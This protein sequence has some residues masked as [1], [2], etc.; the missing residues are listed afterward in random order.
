MT[1][2]IKEGR[3]FAKMWFLEGGDKDWMAAVYRDPGGP[4]ILQYRFRY[5][6]SEDPWDEGDRK[7]WYVATAPPE[8]TEEDIV[9]KTDMMANTMACM[10]FGGKVHPLVL[11]SDDPKFITG[12]MAKQFW[13][14][15]RIEDNTMPWGTR[16]RMSEALKAKLSGECKPG[17]HV[18]EVVDGT[19][20]TCYG[21]SLGHVKEFGGSIGVVHGLTDYNNCKPG[22]EGY[23]RNKVGPEVDVYW[24]PDNLRYAYSPS[25]LEIVKQGAPNEQAVSSGGLD[26]EQA[27]PR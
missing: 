5:Y 17:K 25:D 22:E 20:D 7:S 11:Q 9:G 26:G 15:Q 18:K 12:E 13:S 27:E 23:D 14:H 3:Y 24:E 8:M 16:V 1:I 4:F 10:G 6:R 2:E 21:C 19:D